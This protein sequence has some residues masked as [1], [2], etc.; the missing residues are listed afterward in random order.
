MGLGDAALSGLKNTFGYS[1]KAVITIVDGTTEEPVTSNNAEEETEINE[2]D[3]VSPGTLPSNGLG[4]IAAA[5]GGAVANAAKNAVSSVVDSVKALADKFMS[6]DAKSF[7]V[8]FN[9]A[10]LTLNARRGGVMSSVD[11]TGGKSQGLQVQPPSMSMSVDLVFNKVDPSDAFLD[12][13]IILTQALQGNLKS[14]LNTLSKI[15]G[16]VGYSVQSEIEGLI[17]ACRLYDTVYA[18]FCWGNLCYVGLIDSLECEYKMFNPKGEPIYGV[19]HMSL[20]LVDKDA[21]VVDNQPGRWYSAYAE[22]VKDG[23]VDMNTISNRVGSYL[24]FSL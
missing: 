2:L 24:N 5:A 17:G 6:S 4:N 12:Q 10:T 14:T 18:R 15:T 7:E 16:S 23:S 11:Y 19:V 8:Q 21:G 9:P 13:K 22:L 3:S 20:I 1:S